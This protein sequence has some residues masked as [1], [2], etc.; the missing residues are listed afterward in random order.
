MVYCRFVFWVDVLAWLL[1]R[2]WLWGLCVLIALGLR[3]GLL[4]Y[5][6]VCLRLCCLTFDVFFDVWFRGVR[7]CCLCVARF[8]VWFV[9][10]FGVLS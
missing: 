4:F 6:N 9:R 5:V 8:V 7:S 2:V 3:G 10:T 1:C